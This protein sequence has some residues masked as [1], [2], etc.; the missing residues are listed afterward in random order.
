MNDEIICGY[1]VTAKQ[2]RINAVYIDLIQE[3]DRL[4]KKAGLTWWMY[5]GG[6]IGAVRHKGFIPWDDDID[7]LMPRADFDR[8]RAMTNEEFGAEEPYFLQNFKTEPTCVNALIRFRRSNTTDIRPEHLADI[9]RHSNQLRYNLGISLAIFPLDTVPK[10]PLVQKLQK[11]AVYLLWGV[12]YRTH[13]PNQKRPVQHILCRAVCGVVG[14]RNIMNFCHWLYRTPHKVR[15]DAVQS[16]NGLYAGC[17]LWPKSDFD[18]TVMLPF[19]DIEVPAPSGY[20]DVLT[21]TYGDYMQFPPEDQRVSP[22]GG[23]I[24]PDRSYKEVFP[25]LL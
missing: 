23:V 9:R 8:L 13:H 14:E 7:L 17:L 5:G 15:P 10:S 12:F 16:Y 2:K 25:E 20:D 11:S 4:C 22:H 21:K 6:L 19:E 24:D 1:P 18:E 3:F